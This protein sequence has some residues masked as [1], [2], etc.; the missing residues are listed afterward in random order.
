[1]KL[2]RLEAQAEIFE[3]PNDNGDYR[4]PLLTYARFIFAD[5]R[6]N[7]NKQGVPY[8]EFASLAQSAINMPIKAR[9]LSKTVAGHGGAVPI[10][11][12]VNVSEET[13]EDGTHRLIADAVLYA[14]EFPN[15][16]N[17]LKEAHAS[18]NAPG[19]SWEL[20]YAD[21]EK[22]DG[23]S[24]LK[25]IVARAATFVK[26]PAYGSRTALL[27]LA[28]AEEL[29]D[30]ELSRELTALAS[31]ISPV[32]DKGGTNKVDE[33][34]L[35]AKIEKLELQLVEANTAK[36]KADT[37]LH[38]AQAELQA[39]AEVIQE[40]EK[41]Q[42][43]DTRT[44]KVAEAGLTIEKDA[45]KLAAKQQFWASLSEEAFAEYLGDLVAAKAAATPLRS[46]AA[47]Q[48]P[49][50]PKL[51]GSHEGP[52]NITEL[53]NRLRAASTGATSATE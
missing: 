42:I 38:T 20:R 43:V 19:I 52:V 28:S 5:D 37:E 24:W 50:L 15:E 48:A 7:G 44:K 32:G 8:E 9:F 21:E 34:E 23:V 3:V 35:L 13:T 17:F 29:T 45:D 51:N 14:D 11:H 10:G 18:G 2:A 4:H 27:A 16:V 33:K 41:A 47:S 1:M 39:K 49:Q 12:I 25:G 30:D 31:E 22:K 46:A 40:Y 53:R 26:I 36:A 6:P